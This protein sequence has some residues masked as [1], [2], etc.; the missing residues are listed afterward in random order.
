MKTNPK[1]LAAETK[2]A[3]SG[4]WAWYSNLSEIN[5]ELTSLFI[6]SVLYV[7]KRV[8]WDGI[9]GVWGFYLIVMFVLKPLDPFGTEKTKKVHRFTNNLQ[10]LQK[11][12]VK[13]FS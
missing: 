9:K 13:D 7:Y 11:V 2:A 6:Y 12:M 5:K 10:G 3:S 1:F 4:D 8:K